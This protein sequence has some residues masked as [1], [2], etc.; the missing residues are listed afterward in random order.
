MVTS[1]DGTDPRPSQNR[2]NKLATTSTYHGPY[3]RD[4][5][6]KVITGSHSR[7]SLI[8]VQDRDPAAA[9][10]LPVAY[11]FPVARCYLYN[12]RPGAEMGLSDDSDPVASEIIAWDTEAASD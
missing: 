1:R 7:C 3:N 9:G 5:P 10:L 8:S 6:V 2:P 11:E 4:L 12:P